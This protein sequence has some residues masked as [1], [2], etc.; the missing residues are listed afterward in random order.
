MKGT[1]YMDFNDDV[2]YFKHSHILIENQYD[3]QQSGNKR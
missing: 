2:L 1:V 3:G